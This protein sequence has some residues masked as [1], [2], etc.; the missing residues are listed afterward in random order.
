MSRNRSHCAECGAYTGRRTPEHPCPFYVMP[1]RE[2]RPATDTSFIAEAR[3]TDD[4]LKR[5]R[6]S[7]R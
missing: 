7:L 2:D 1:Q 6:R 3:N 5:Y 4:A